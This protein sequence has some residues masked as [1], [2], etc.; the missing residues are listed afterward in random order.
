MNFLPYSGKKYMSIQIT[1]D[2]EHPEPYVLAILN[3]EKLKSAGVENPV[4]MKVKS[5]PMAIWLLKNY[6]FDNERRRDPHWDHYVDTIISAAK[7]I[8]MKN[9]VDGSS[10][11]EWKKRYLSLDP[12]YKFI[13]SNIA[14][15]LSPL[16]KRGKTLEEI[17]DMIHGLSSSHREDVSSVL[18][19]M[20]DTNT[21]IKDDRTNPPRYR[22]QIKPNMFFLRSRMRVFLHPKHK[23]CR[24]TGGLSPEKIVEIFRNNYNMDVDLKMVQPVLSMMCEDGTIKETQGKYIR[25]KFGDPSY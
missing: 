24:H 23:H 25:I 3:V 17:I 8:G 11:E 18:S 21:I 15:H 9:A 20:V 22:R 10:F 19:V 12:E 14:Q 2:N 16:D 6:F 1:I 13:T 5:P 7:E 4:D